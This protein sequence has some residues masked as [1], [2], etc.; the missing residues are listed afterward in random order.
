MFTPTKPKTAGQIFLIDA[1]KIIPNKNQPREHFDIEALRALSD[2]IRKNGIIQPLT[3]RRKGDGKY[4]LVAGERRLRAAKMANLKGIPCIIMEIDDRNSAMFAL[5]ENIQRQELNFI[6]EAKAIQKLSTIYGMR[7]EDIAIGIGKTQSAV[8]NLLRVLRLSPEIQT[9]LVEHGL[10]QRHA[11][12]LLK[13]SEQ[14]QREVLKYII[15]K[16]LSVKQ[17]EELVEK[18]LS[19]EPKHKQH[20][21]IFFK[22]VKIFVNT[23]NHAVEVMQSAGIKAQYEKTESED[24]YRFVVTVPKNNA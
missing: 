17:T 2:S 1:D 19:Q 23:I 7:Q 14:Q 21:K 18:H 3:V 12:A 9:R 5:I 20:R 11:R 13:L 6:E 16:K 8:S 24:E 4:E 15:E 22:D 10:S